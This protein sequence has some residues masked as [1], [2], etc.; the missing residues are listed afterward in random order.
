MSFLEHCAKV[1]G[2]IF[3]LKLRTKAPAF[4]VVSNPEALQQILTSDNKEISAPGELN[5]VFEYLLGKD[6]VI[7]LSGKEH[8]RQR[9]L[10]L[11]PFHGERMR[12]YSQVIIDTTNLVIS[13]Y[14]INQP[15]KI[16]S[17]SQDITLKVIMQAVF[18]LNEGQ[19]ALELQY[20]LSEILQDSG[21]VWKNAAILAPG[22]RKIPGISQLWEQQMLRQQQ[23]SQLI[24]EEIQERRENPDPSH[25]DILSLLMVAQDE[26]GQPMSDQELHDELLTL[27]VAGHETTATAIAW[28]FYWIHK[29]PSV[30]VKL[31]AELDNLTPNTDAST[32][33]K[34]PYLNA[35]CCET[36]RIYPVGMST[37]PRQVKTPISLSGY[38]LPVD[39]ILLGS[40]YLTHHREDL[41]PEP[42]LFRPERFLEQQFSPYEY[43]PFGGGARRCIGLAF[44]QLEMKLAIA[45][46]LSNYEL[47]LINTKDVKPKR[48]GLVTGPDHPIRMKI[49][50]RRQALSPALV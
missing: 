35:V 20:R 14:Q 17:V 24:Y 45:Q 38:K 31:L 39:T 10:L 11:P 13:Q 9:Q 50:S 29:I 2:D 33:F 19:R 25:T 27:L 7:T 47:E 21:T 34:L 28:A 44:A 5:R 15:F 49:K 26:E 4:I 1:Y 3:T 42:H 12:K 23:A 32:I 43:L 18:G 46:I 41:Y 36:L 6:S 16:R 22:L 48:R 8:Q 30:R 37:F 40:I